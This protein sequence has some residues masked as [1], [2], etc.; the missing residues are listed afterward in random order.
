MSAVRDNPFQ[1][2]RSNG[3]ADWSS[4][5]PA[6][7]GPER[8]AFPFGERHPRPSLRVVPEEGEGGP[9]EQSLAANG[10]IC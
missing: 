3:R 4:A 1:R 5:L 10:P 9:D 2:R 7:P 6:L 8:S